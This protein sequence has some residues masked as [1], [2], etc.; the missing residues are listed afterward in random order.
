M[1]GLVSTAAGWKH[2]AA[3]FCVHVTPL[4]HHSWI[5]LESLSSLCLLVVKQE[6]SIIDNTVE[7]RHCPHSPAG[8][9]CAAPA[10]T[11]AGVGAG[12]AP[13]LWNLDTFS[14]FFALLLLLVDKGSSSS[15]KLSSVA[16]LGLLGSFLAVLV[17]EGGGGGA[18]SAASASSAS[19]ESLLRILRCFDMFDNLVG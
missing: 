5:R 9:L 12:A 14:F 10:S 1:Q 7:L 17:P 2:L 16:F 15:P 13:A 6:L 18:A 11:A 19:D 3:C 4:A 8:G